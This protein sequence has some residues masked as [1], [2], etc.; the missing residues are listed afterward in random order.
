MGRTPKHPSQR[1]RRNKGPN[2]GGQEESTTK[3][4][5]SGL[6]REAPP[7]PG[8]SKAHPRAKEWWATIW[9]SPMAAVW[10]DAD[11]PALARCAHLISRVWREGDVPSHVLSEI[12]HIEDRFGLSPLARRRLQWEIGRALG[13]RANEADENAPATVTN[14]ER[15]RRA[16][17]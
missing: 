6:T 17:G 2:G 8:R 1:R 10:V 13:E 5:E 4:P 14:M 11:V 12:R 7:L 3:L 15:F 16:I 9:A